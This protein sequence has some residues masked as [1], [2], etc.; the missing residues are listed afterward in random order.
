MSLLVP[1]LNL[2]QYHLAGV[3]E[4]SKLVLNTSELHIKDA[5]ELSPRTLVMC[6]T[7]L[8]Y[9]AYQLVQRS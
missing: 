4:S 6:W 8:L 1:C 5:T 7:F 3:S 2:N 9:S